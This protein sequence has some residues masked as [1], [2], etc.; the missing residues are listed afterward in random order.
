MKQKL[1]FN[2]ETEETRLKLCVAQR[3]F[4]VGVTIIDNI[5]RAIDKSEKVICIIS[6]A[7]IHSGWCKEELRLAHQVLMCIFVTAR[8][9]GW[10]KVLFSQAWEGCHTP[11]QGYV[12]LPLPLPPTPPPPA[13]TRTV[14]RRGQLLSRRRTFLFNLI[15]NFGNNIAF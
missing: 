12:S 11:G 1:L 2:L 5:M 7:F 13:R 14:V 15:S 6:K 3:N 4:V 8:T 9:E 10:G